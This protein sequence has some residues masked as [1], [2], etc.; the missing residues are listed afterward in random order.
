MNPSEEFR[1]FAGECRAM[2]KLTRSP[3]SKATWV[4][5]AN[6]QPP[7]VP[8]RHAQKLPSLLAGQPMLSYRSN[9]SSN[10]VTKTSHS[11][12]IR[13]IPALPEQAK[14]MDNSR[15]TKGPTKSCC[16]LSRTAK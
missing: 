12:V 6:A 3:D 7:E 13:H 1:K 14:N 16:P 4:L 2:A 5:V 10:R 8:S 15:A 9:A 11:N